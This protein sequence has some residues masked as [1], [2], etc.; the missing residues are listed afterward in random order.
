MKKTCITPEQKKELDKAIADGEF[1]LK[2]IKKTKSSAERTELVSK[3]FDDPDLVKKVVR[4]IETRFSSKKEEIINKYMERNFSDVPA[5]TRKGVLNKFKRMQTLLGAKTEEEFMEELVAHKFGAVISKAE[6]NKLEKTTI[7]AMILKE[8][9]PP[10]AKDITDES[11]AY[12]EKLVQLENE[13]AVIFLAKTEFKFSDK[14]KFKGQKGREAL[15][16]WSKHLLIAASEYSGATRAFKATADVSGFLR[17][18]AK[19]ALG[20]AAE[21]LFIMAGKNTTKHNMKFKIWKN[22]F[23]NTVEAVQKTSKYGDHRFYD[24]VRAEVHAHPNSY[25]GVYDAASNSYGLRAGVEEQF[26]SSA[27][28]DWYDKYLTKKLGVTKKTNI[29]KISEVA[30]NAVVL[31]SRF[32]LANETIS[33]LKAVD[34]VNIMDKKWADPAG[35]FVSA[36][37]GRGG[38]GKLESGSALFNK[39]LFAPKYAASQFSPYF[40]IAKGLSTEADNAAARFAMSQ[41]IQFLAG[42]AGLALTAETF[43]AF[44]EGEDPDWESVYDPRSNSFGKVKFPYTDRSLDFTGGNRSVAGLKSGIFSKKFY[45]A[46]LGIWREKGFF[47]TVEGKP[48]Y[49]F[50]SGKF[51]PVPGVVRDLMKGEQFGGEE[52]PS[53]LTGNFDLEDNLWTTANVVKNLLMPITIENVFLDEGYE[54][55][56][57]SAA[58]L[59][60]AAEVVGIGTTDI[61]FKPQN[62]NW[63]ALLNTDK[64]A[65][66]RAVD[67]MWNNV[68]ARIE[69]LRDSEAFQALPLDVQRDRLERVYT[70]ELDR[71]IKQSKYR[72]PEYREALKEIKDKKKESIL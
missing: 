4:D 25:N 41:N 18:N 52:L 26:P 60:A 33:I 6:A 51:A 44:L 69:K 39:I 42:S 45:D 3:Y 57:L 9:I 53:I 35:E 5:E 30:F 63:T 72:T 27:P 71:V 23:W 36:F 7:E 62:D 10:G 64:K 16:S 24:S 55:E 20:S 13:E 8:K 43:R 46:R 22:S 59:V 12:G 11:L 34:G 37:T 2:K 19:L 56:D 58:I 70:T 49:D 66:W 47:Q 15:A 31:K 68:Q 54:K 17:Q 29:F 61:R 50:I 67:E 38:L 14:D 48:F 21:Q 28:S 32:E 40:Q 1:S 65:Y